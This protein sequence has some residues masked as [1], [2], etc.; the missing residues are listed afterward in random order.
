MP[1]PNIILIMSDQHRGDF[2]GIEGQRSLQTT[3]LDALAASGVWFSRAYSSCPTCIAA[4]RSM[5][6][7][8]FPRTHG[9]V[10]YAEKQHWNAP[11]SLPQVL[12][13]AGYHTYFVGRDMHQHPKRRRFGYDHMVITEDYNAW[14]SRMIPYET[15]HEGGE[16]HPDSIRYSYGTM[17]ND[18]TAHPWT[19]DEQLHFTN[20]TMMQAK[21]F[22][23]I[24]DPGQPFF[25]TISFSA[26]HQPLTPPAFYF[27]RYLRQE[28]PDPAIGDWA[29]RPANDGIG[30]DA[31][32]VGWGAKERSTRVCL[33]GELRRSA[34]AGYYGSINHNDDQIR[35]LIYGINGIDFGNTAVLYVADHGEMLGDHYYWRKSLPYEGSARIPFIVR[36]PNGM[37]SLRGRRSMEAVCLE[38][39]MPTIL[40]IAGVPIP[41]TVEGRSLLPLI[42]GRAES[43]GRPYLH[44]E[45]APIHQSLTD[46]RIKYVWFV[47]DG[48]EQLFDLDRDPRELHDCIGD[49]SYRETAALWRGRLVRELQGRPEGFVADGKLVAGRPYPALLGRSST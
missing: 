23:K 26:P 30:L 15:G 37:E 20:W 39:L 36:L 17:H 5:L 14:V 7:G 18:Y 13:D 27:D 48:K 41:D 22:M 42:Q 35:R 2:L 43:L 12:R 28:L 21:R 46:G 24:R 8:Q 16:P 34:L 25:L 40:D 31:S 9:L 32:G 6:S 45:H 44:I 49:A 19:Y 10:G 3:N 38:D 11:P 47:D 4:R 29:I 33:E 1:Q